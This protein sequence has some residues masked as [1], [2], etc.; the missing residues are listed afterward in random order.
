[1]IGV[2]RFPW[3]E[4]MEARF[5]GRLCGPVLS[6]NLI[7]SHTHLAS[8]SYILLLSM[9]ENSPDFSIHLYISLTWYD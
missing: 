8:K 4:A 7:L 9:S 1:M 6:T 5:G 3:R 2:L